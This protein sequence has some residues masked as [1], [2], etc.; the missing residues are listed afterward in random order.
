MTQKEYYEHR[1]E[2]SRKALMALIAKVEH[3]IGDKL[4]DV[5]VQAVNKIEELQE[6]ARELEDDWEG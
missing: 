1:L 5:L 6:E 3:P 4:S 2:E